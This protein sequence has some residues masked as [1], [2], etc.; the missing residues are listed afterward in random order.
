M[1]TGAMG[2][3]SPGPAN[4][5]T[6]NGRIEALALDGNEIAYDVG[7]QGVANKVVVWNVRTGKTTTVSGKHTRTADDSSTG[8]G[9]FELAIAGSHVAWA[10]NVGGNTEGDYYVYASSVTKPKERQVAMEQ[11]LGDTCAGRQSDCAGPWLGG[12]VGS[13]RL[14]AFNRWT[15]DASGSVVDGALYVLSGTTMKSVATGV[16]TVQA[17]SADG[18]RLAAFQSGSDVNVYTS[19]GRFVEAVS[20]GSP[21]AAALS[22]HSLVVLTGTRKLETWDLRTGKPGKAFSVQASAKQPAG[23][24]DVRG[25][26]AIYTTGPSLHAVNLSSGKDRVIGTLR[27][28]VAFA[29][30][31]SAGVAYS[32]GRSRSRGTIVFVP[33][34]RVA[35]A[36]R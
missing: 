26:I 19:A 32:T 12:L 20:A 2:K 4:T 21:Q 10:V 13:G 29:R 18:D 16:L 35:A 22:G 30:I 1:A 27:G 34:A 8:A 24:L 15:T 28:S 5:R 3:V 9:V 31:D 33:S 14:I 6:I 36:V 7:P 17:A 11:R 25:N 23:N